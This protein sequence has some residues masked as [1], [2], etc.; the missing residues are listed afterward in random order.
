VV[1]H[2]GASVPSR[3][4]TAEHAAAVARALVAAGHRVLVT[5]GPAE[6]TLTAAVVAAARGVGAAGVATG[7]Q[8][9]GARDAAVVDLGGRT[10]FAELASVLAGAACVVVGNT[11]PAHLAAAVRTPVVS[12]FSPVVPVERWAPWGVPTVVL[13]DQTALCRGSRARECPVPGHPCLTSVAPSEVVD[14]VGRLTAPTDA[15]AL[16]MEAR[17]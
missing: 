7:G 8:D 16:R 15:P 13:G 14:A 4:L 2:P 5:G 11:G 1:L 10:T 3:G 12:L 17:A 9:V 6:T